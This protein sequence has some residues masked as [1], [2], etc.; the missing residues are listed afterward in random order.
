LHAPPQFGPLEA[1]VFKML[2]DDEQ[3][4][5]AAFGLGL[6]DLGCEA[7]ALIDDFQRLGSDGSKLGFG[8]EAEHTLF[9][10]FT[11]AG[12]EVQSVLGH[13]GTPTG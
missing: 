11:R 13:W 10:A 6:L 8:F 1:Q 7:D 4:H 3:V 2:L 12:S 9:C 5:G